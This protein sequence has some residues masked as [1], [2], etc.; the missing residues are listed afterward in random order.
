MEKSGRTDRTT[1]EQWPALEALPGETRRGFLKLAATLGLTLW[2]SPGGTAQLVFAQ[3]EEITG[4]RNPELTGVLVRGEVRDLW[5][6]FTFIGATW[7]NSELT[8]I[9]SRQDLKRILDLKTGVAP[10]YL[11]EY[12]EGLRIFRTLRAQLGEQEA[13]R[14][15]FF[16]TP[17][18]RLRQF[19]VLEFL[20]LQVASGGFARF[21]GYRNYPGF[22][23]GP[24]DDPSNPPYRPIS[25]PAEG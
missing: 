9:A 19:V 10:S 11:T 16:E 12:R 15:V 4:P 2:V 22:P 7:D 8:T 17:D 1:L 18:P 13:L 25:P 14:L 23:G 24:F 3:D 20:R 6:I 5:T 21:G